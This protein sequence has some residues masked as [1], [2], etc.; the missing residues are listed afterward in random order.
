[1]P[2]VPREGKGIRGKIIMDEAELPS[3]DDWADCLVG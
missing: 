1:V 3:V 2:Y